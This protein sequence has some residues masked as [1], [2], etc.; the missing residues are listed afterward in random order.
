[1]HSSSGANPAHRSE[2]L[3]DP[4]QRRAYDDRLARERSARIWSGATRAEPLR[5][6]RCPVEPLIPPDKRSCGIAAAQRNL[7]SSDLS[8]FLW[9]DAADQPFRSTDS[10]LTEI[11]DWLW[12]DPGGLAWPQSRPVQSIDVDIPL[13]PEQALHGGRVHVTIPVQAACPACWGRGSVGLVTCWHCAGRGT[14]TREG[15]IAVPFPAGTPDNHVVSV[16]LD[17]LGMPDLCLAIHFR[18]R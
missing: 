15:T 16:S 4:Q 11:L 12:S 5:A 13:S 8:R 17:R 2:V 18:V 3:G 1:M 7:C 9:G 10:P 14:V 6:R